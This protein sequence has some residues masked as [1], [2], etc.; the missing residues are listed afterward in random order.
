MTVKNKATLT[1]ML[2]TASLAGMFLCWSFGHY[3]DDLAEAFQEKARTAGL[4]TRESIASSEALLQSELSSLL[5]GPPRLAE[6]L[7]RRDRERLHEIAR[8]ILARLRKGRFQSPRL[9]FYLPDGRPFLQ[10][11][12]QN[13]ANDA[14]SDSSPTAM[15]VHATRAGAAG[16]ESR[17]GDILFLAVQPVFLR[18]E[19]AG[20]VELGVD[21]V[22]LAQ[23]VEEAVGA[24][25]AFT[26]EPASLGPLRP[27]G[28]PEYLP[29]GS[30]LLNPLHNAA[31]FSDLLRG[32]QSGSLPQQGDHAGLTW[33]LY[34][35]GVLTD[36][37]Q[38]VLARLLL[39]QDITRERSALRGSGFRAL[40]LSLGLLAATLVV[41]RRGF[42]TMV[43][44]TEELN[45]SLEGK[46]EE[47]TRD[48]NALSEKLRHSNK[49]L[50]QIFNSAADGMRIV[51][52]DFN[53]LR[54]NDTF[55][56]MARLDRAKVEGIKCYESFR[57]PLC[58]T[59]DCPLIRLQSGQERLEADVEKTRQDG[60]VISC[61]LTATPFRGLGGELVGIIEDF[62]DINVRKS[63]L[64]ALRASEERYRTVANHIYDW[65]SWISPEGRALFVSPSCE[66]I[67]GYPASQFLHEPEFIEG[68]IHKEDLHLWQRQMRDESRREGLPLDFRIITRSGEE[69]WVSQE[70]RRAF[71]EQGGD[72]GLRTSIRDI[73]GRKHM[74]QK[75]T[76]QALHDPLTGLANRS[77]CLDRIRGASQRA[78]RREAY[79]FAVVFVDL[80]RFKSIN[81]G[82]GHSCG[83]DLLIEFSRR[84]AGIVRSLD[85]VS[86][87][88][89]DEFVILL[90]ELPSLRRVIQ[91]VK[92]VRE[93]LATPFTVKGYEVQLTASFGIA[94]G[95][96]GTQRPEDLLQKANIAMHRAKEMGRDRIKVF[97]SRMLEQAILYMTL[98]NDMRRAIA[99]NEFSLAY[100]P[101]YSLREHHLVGFEALL[102]WDHP[103][104]AFSGPGEFIHLAEETGLIIELGKWALREACAT[105]SLLRACHPWARDLKMSVNISPR[106]FSQADL[107]QSITHI[108]CETE[109]PPD[110]L[111]LEITET[112][113]MENAAV[114]VDKL[115]RLKSLGI[116]ISVDDF[117][118]GYSS[119]AYLQRLPLD[120]LKIDLSFVRRIETTPEN[121]L[122]VKA[123]I[124][125]AHSLGLQVV[126]EGIEKEAHCDHLNAL[127]CEF[128]QGFFFSQPLPYAEAESLVARGPC[129]GGFPRT[130]P[131][132]GTGLKPALPVL[133]GGDPPKRPP[134]PGIPEF[135]D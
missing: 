111:R 63:T 61:I 51:D 28:M 65:E 69:R 3:R 52:R 97:N 35:G 104:H 31:L 108:L 42:G 78:A 25:A 84:I 30:V 10:S 133:H 76:H 14:P 59:P 123:I 98:E 86:R 114:A 12:A 2:F 37:R 107:V 110:R 29:F 89:G 116:T 1:V 62:K 115:Q 53:V 105:L 50:D 128:G 33:V 22:E 106:Q 4:V 95:I 126:A 15:H 71:D 39:A 43:D 130:A 68:I 99:R 6:A 32:V 21:V 8:P 93:S 48:L 83:D 60:S 26:L 127:D 113:I 82:F 41:L 16:H 74:E 11:P 13:P 119:M 88:G 132:N 17:A 103:G 96:D 20:A 117:G 109:I 54:A 118:T 67:T 122:I 85:T 129:L 44:K 58:R 23:H 40:V 80:D 134:C 19:Y 47:R 34:D 81:D 120:I 72:L 64:K 79:R 5:S 56:A 9:G 36:Y 38:E 91:F 101:I 124:S 46:I 100:Q 66:R 77:L 7:A 125:L 90:E 75:L 92:R 131:S 18:G 24:K 135:A 57:G 49:E 55:S 27:A 45:R 94:F 102:R 70:W 112:A 73:T 121:Q 87:F